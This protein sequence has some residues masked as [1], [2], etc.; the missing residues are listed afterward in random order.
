[1]ADS[2]RRVIGAAVESQGEV[3]GGVLLPRRFHCAVVKMQS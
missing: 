3:A 2:G 1:M